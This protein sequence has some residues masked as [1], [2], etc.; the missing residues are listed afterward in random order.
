MDR[1]VLAMIGCAAFASTGD[2]IAA[3]A[4]APVDAGPPLAV[5]AALQPGQWALKARDG[6][7]A[8]KTL[9]LGDPR[10]LLQI[11]HTGAACSRFVI[12][13]DPHQAIVHYA[14]AGAGHG[15]TTLRMETSRLIQID[16]QGIA[17]REPFDLAYEGRRVGECSVATSGTTALR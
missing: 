4:P 6:S 16:S 3:P 8:V 2:A 7:G 11:R 10:V 14:C 13:N 9:C 1:F 17:N 15:R 5:L 12:N